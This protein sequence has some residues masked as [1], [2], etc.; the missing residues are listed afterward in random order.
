LD[1]GVERVKVFAFIDSQKTEFDVKTL[2]SVCAVSRSSYYDWAAEAAGGPDDGVW[3]EAILANRIYDAWARSRGR[4]GSPRVTAALWRAGVRVNHKR[5]EQI[6]VELGIAGRGGRRKLRTTVRDPNAQP[7]SDLV[8]RDFVRDRPDRLWVGDITYIPTRE[9]W[10]Y[11]ASVLDACTRRLVGW[12]IADHMRT[13]LCSDALR[14]AAA[15]RRRLRLDGVVFHS[16]HGGQYTSDDY[17]LLCAD[18]HVVQSMGTVGD[19][20]DNAM[21]ES[22]WSSLKRELLDADY[23]T[24]DEARIAVFEWL[25]WYNR[26]RL[27]TSIGFCPPEEYEENLLRDQAA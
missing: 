26:E 11:V 9:G 15:T 2:C 16:D 1:E 27:H 21:A 24:K 13:E 3:D 25:V 7:A 23:R 20:Y 5:V 17:R 19:S 8:R 14:A 12:S 10:L 22:F 18:L 6:M 4:Y